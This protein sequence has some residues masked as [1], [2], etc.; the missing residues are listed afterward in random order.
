[1]KDNTQTLIRKKRLTVINRYVWQRGIFASVCYE[2]CT[3]G[4]KS[5]MIGE[6]A[7]PLINAVKGG[8]KAYVYM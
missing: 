3:L 2:L 8:I 4:V 7:S 1:M 6:H 5:D